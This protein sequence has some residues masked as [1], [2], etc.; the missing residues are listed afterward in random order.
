MATTQ[1]AVWWARPGGN[2][3]NGAGFDSSI[4]GAGTN[5]AN[6]DTAQLT[7]TDA[8][9]SNVS[10]ALTIPASGT[11]FSA[12][13]VGNAVAIVISA[14]YSCHRFITAFVSATEVT[15]DATPPT[16]SAGAA[17]IRI[18]GA[19]TFTNTGFHP[20]GSAPSAA[21][22]SGNKLWIKGTGITTDYTISSNSLNFSIVASNDKPFTAEGYTTTE[23]DGGRPILTT[24]ASALACVTI[25]GK[26]N[27]VKNLSVNATGAAFFG[28]NVTNTN[29][30]IRK[31]VCQGIF[32]AKEQGGANIWIDCEFKGSAAGNAGMSQ[33]AGECYFEG[34]SFHGNA[35]FGLDAGNNG[36]SEY[37]NCLFYANTTDGV[38]MPA[39]LTH[40][41]RFVNCVFW[42]NGRDGIRNDSTAATGGLYDWTIR[43]CIFGK[44]VGYDVNF[45]LEDA[46]LFSGAIEW[47]AVYL[48]CNAFYT[49]GTGKMHFLPAN[50]GDITLTASPFTSDTVF[51]LNTTSG[52]GAAVTA[53]ICTTTLPDANVLVIP[54][55]FSATSSSVAAV[56]MRSLWREYTGELSTEISDTVVDIYLQAG[57]EAL[58]RRVH[59][60][61][62]TDESAV[63]L[64]AGTQEYTLP[65]DCIEVLWVYLNGS[66]LQKRDVEDWDKRE[67]QWR[68]EAA[69]TPTE[70]AH[71]GNRIIFRPK[72]NALAVA[73][74]STPSIRYISTPPSITTSGP[75]QL[76]SEDY[77]TCVLYG[78]AQWSVAHPDAALAVQRAKGF[79]DMFNEET[80][81]M[82]EEY[83]NRSLAR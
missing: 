46:T 63:T 39:G 18:G 45:T 53:G 41:L 38:N 48:E 15:L 72:P 34:C 73:A 12:D 24:S 43:R 21:P 7:R 60:H 23:G 28:L 44:N 4:S 64:V 49:T 1:F 9:T 59:Y 55:G 68:E 76:S 79:M 14:T 32:P 35:T 80:Q 81:G 47:A 10:T 6:Q 67:E 25:S 70:Y 11:P 8:T 13:L 57:L 19:T 36:P 58:N 74:D 30:L 22:V 77:R 2:I 3:F 69:G 51:T 42:N 54:I 40:G 17:T 20:L 29:N 62:T 78:A 5:Y 71:E 50:S 56:S 65:S 31:V 16:S 26:F 82:A 27:I 61:Y 37:A 66:K 75:E 52:G 33:T 83:R